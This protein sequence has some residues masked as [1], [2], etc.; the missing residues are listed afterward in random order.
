MNKIWSDHELKAAKYAQ[1]AV[2]HFTKAA[3]YNDMG[4]LKMALHYALLAANDMDYSTQHAKHANDYC[5][6]FMINDQF[7]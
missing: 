7:E 6:R 5:Y 3:L 4:N 1:N 2:E